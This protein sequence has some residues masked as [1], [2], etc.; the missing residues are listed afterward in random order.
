MLHAVL[1][2]AMQNK[3]D[4]RTLNELLRPEEQLEET[5]DHLY[6]TEEDIDRIEKNYRKVNEK[7]DVTGFN[8]TVGE[9]SAGVHKDQPTILY[10]EAAE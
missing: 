7:I 4:I 8:M 2:W 5:S 10:A 9:F 6:L 3:V 1:V